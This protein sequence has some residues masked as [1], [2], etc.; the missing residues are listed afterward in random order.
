MLSRLTA[1]HVVQGP[2]SVSGS[3]PFPAR[4]SCIG[5]VNPAICSKS[6]AE[7]RFQVENLRG[8]SAIHSS[9]PIAGWPA[10]RGDLRPPVTP[11]NK[12][13]GGQ[14]VLRGLQRAPNRQTPA[15]AIED[16]DHVMP[17]LVK[18]SAHPITLL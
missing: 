13:E 4:T 16:V 5:I 8:L 3:P 10:A 15:S 9:A 1:E 2:T 17:P 6:A 11:G 14:P 12:Q 7:S 18:T